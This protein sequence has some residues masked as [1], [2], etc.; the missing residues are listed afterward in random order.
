MYNKQFSHP[1]G[2]TGVCMSLAVE[3]GDDKVDVVVGKTSTGIRS[4]VPGENDD[5]KLDVAKRT[6]GIP[7]RTKHNIKIW[8]VGC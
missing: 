1:P 7:T 6:S 2:G 5:N 3:N 4:S 8:D